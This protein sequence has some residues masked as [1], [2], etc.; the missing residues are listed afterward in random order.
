MSICDLKIHFI[1]EASEVS[2]N[3]LDTKVSIHNNEI[4]T[5]LY[6]DQQI[7]TIT[8]HSPPHTLGT[9]NI[10]FPSANT[11]K[12]GGFAVNFLILTN[13]MKEMKSIS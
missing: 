2:L 5:D 1:H 8:F 11:Y 10:A 12:V 9:A 13:H 7:H 4:V 6:C 3:F